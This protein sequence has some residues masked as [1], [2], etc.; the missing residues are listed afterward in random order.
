MTF[1]ALV[2]ILI[3]KG[4][5]IPV[6]LKNCVPYCSNISPQYDGWLWVERNTYVENE[7][8]TSELLKCLEQT[9]SQKP[10]EDLTTETINIGGFAQTQLVFVIGLNLA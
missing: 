4:L 6:F 10:L 9:S 5:V 2:I 7:I 1:T 3:M 8:D